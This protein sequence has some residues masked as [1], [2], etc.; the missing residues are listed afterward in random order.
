MPSAKKVKGAS[1]REKTSNT[2]ATRIAS[3]SA[4]SMARFFGTTSP[5][6]DVRIADEQE[7][8]RKAHH[9]PHRLPSAATMMG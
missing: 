3:R 5:K 1:S 2:G 8:D 4:F 6:H 9:V 7:G